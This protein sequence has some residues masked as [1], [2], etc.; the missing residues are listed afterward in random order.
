ML[1]FTLLQLL[2]NREKRRIIK[3]IP[4]AEVSLRNEKSKVKIQEVLNCCH[5]EN[6]ANFYHLEKYNKNSGKDKSRPT[7]AVLMQY[8]CCR[9]AVAVYAQ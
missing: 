2:A 8:C 4:G 9:M 5:Q 7:G 3:S 1:D 6:F